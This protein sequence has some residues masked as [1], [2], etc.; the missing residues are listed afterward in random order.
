METSSE[1]T[2]GPLDTT[3]DTCNL[4]E[5]QISE[6]IGMAASTCRTNIL[7]N[8][9]HL[10]HSKYQSIYMFIFFFLPEAETRG[11]EREKR[12]SLPPAKRPSSG[13]EEMENSIATKRPRIHQQNENQQVS[14]RH[15]L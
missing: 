13:C 15:T 12:E 2:T 7:Y 11:E 3:K 9:L 8:I 14:S 10:I 6:E 5:K 4:G 1:S